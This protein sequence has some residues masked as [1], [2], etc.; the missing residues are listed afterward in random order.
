MAK[1]RLNPLVKR[2][3]TRLGCLTCRDRHMKC[4]E[5]HPVCK[6]CIK[7]KR[8]CYRGIRLNFTQY[9]I[10]NPMAPPQ[11]PHDELYRILD[12]LITIA[13]LYKNGRRQYQPY[14]HLH[15]AQDL[16]DADQ[17]Y[18]DAHLPEILAPPPLVGPL[19]AVRYSVVGLELASCHHRPLHGPHGGVYGAP[20]GSA[21]A[22]ASSAS[23]V[24]T[25]AS[26]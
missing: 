3:R 11:P 26:L 2:S 22:A 19:L 25:D 10:Y 23:P 24:G 16:H 20:N 5:Q 6:N 12:Q 4:D 7:L 17:H 18:N 1:K 14:L 21:R 8:K 15:T 13:L 9:T